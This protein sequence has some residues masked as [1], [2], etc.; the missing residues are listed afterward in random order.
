M[1]VGGCRSFLLL[2]ITRN[3]VIW[4]KTMIDY[5]HLNS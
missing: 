2:V 1:V 4:K 3:A 5:S